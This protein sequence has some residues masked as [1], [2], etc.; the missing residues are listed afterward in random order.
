MTREPFLAHWDHVR[1][2]VGIGLRLVEAVP[3]SKL[4]AHPVP[5]MRSPKQLAHH[6]FATLRELLEGLV[7]GDV[8]D[9]EESDAEK[10]HSKAELVRFCHDCWAGANRAAQSVT[11]EQLSAVVK[12]PWGHDLPG[13]YVPVIASDEFLHHRGQMF[14]YVRALGGEVPEM[15]DFSHNAE[16]FRP[17]AAVKA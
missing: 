4:D 8:R 5:K 6:Q 17:A 12:T 7:R 3:E 15:W 11:D 10:I 9:A 14:A 2:L 1:Q 16:E 13:G